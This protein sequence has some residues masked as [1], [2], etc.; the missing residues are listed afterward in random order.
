MIGRLQRV[1]LREVWRHEAWD[2]TTWL[3]ENIDLLEEELGLSFGTV[4]REQAAGNFSVDLLAED[5]DGHTVV[6]ENQLE[7]SDHDHLGKLIT[8][9]AAFN[10]QTAIWLVSEARPEHTAAV[11]WLNQSTPTS[12]YLVKVEAVRIA[13][14][15][16]APLLTLIVGSSPETRAVAQTKQDLNEQHH[17]MQEFWSGLKQVADTK[18]N[19]HVNSSIGKG[20]WF[21]AETGVPGVFLNYIARIDDGRVE[22]YIFTGDFHRNRVIFTKLSEHQK[23][24][25]QELGATLIWNDSPDRE[26]CKIELPVNCPGYRNRED[27]LTTF[28]ALTDSMVKFEHAFRPHLERIKQLHLDEDQ[29]V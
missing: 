23:A 20:T 24:I 15:P 16:P 12:F 14:S 7:K 9:L 3:E 6:I 17:L 1:P 8:Y 25:E 2:F 27:W 21:S 29:L 5:L 22:I 11:A 10:A 19:L 28:E 18:T 4:N 13:D 26:V